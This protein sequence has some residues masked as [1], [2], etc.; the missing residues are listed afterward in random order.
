M[1]LSSSQKHNTV[2]DIKIQRLLSSG[3]ELAEYLLATAKKVMC[4][5]PSYSFTTYAYRKESYLEIK[6]K[7]HGGKRQSIRSVP[8]WL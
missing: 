7:F 3:T 6:D 5:A 4:H 1:N 8:N 2:A